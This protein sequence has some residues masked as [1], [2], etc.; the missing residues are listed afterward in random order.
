MH[1]KS[2]VLDKLKIFKAQVE[3]QHE[4]FIK[5]FGS[6][7]GWGFYHPKY[8][9]STNIVHQTTAPYYPQQNGIAKRKN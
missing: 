6:D 4:T 5:S 9:E 8:F 3:V 7:M 2:E 1:S